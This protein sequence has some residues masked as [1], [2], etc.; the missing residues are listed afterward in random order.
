MEQSH[1]R[2]ARL[3]QSTSDPQWHLVRVTQLV[4]SRSADPRHMEN[5][6]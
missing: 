5:N 6:K 1:P 4:W 2:Q 3:H